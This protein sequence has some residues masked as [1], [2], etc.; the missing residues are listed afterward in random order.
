MT[1]RTVPPTGRGPATLGAAAPADL[2]EA[3]DRRRRRGQVLVIALVT[4]ALGSSR[5]VVNL[6]VGGR[7]AATATST[8][9]VVA[10]GAG[11]LAGNVAAA[12]F[13]L[14]CLGVVVANVAQVRRFPQLTALI[15]FL[16]FFAVV[17]VADFVANEASGLR[18]SYYAIAVLLVVGWSVQPRF[19]D[20]GIIGAVGLLVAVASLA[21]I[22][23]GTGWMS[24]SYATLNE[25]ALIGD[26]TLGGIYPQG[27]ILGMVLSSTM[28][29]ML[30]FKRR[31]LG[32]ASFAVG[33]WA[34]L[35][36][37]SRTSWAGLAVSTA[38]VLV[39]LA[40]R[41]GRV[42]RILT[43][44]GAVAITSVV[45]ALPILTTDPLAFT[46]RGQIW[47]YSREH[48]GSPTALLFGSGL[49]VYGI[50]GA[51]AT[52]LGAPSY[53][54]H[55]EFVTLMT[56]SG[57]VA[58]VLF[59]VLFGLAVAR[60]LM[61]PIGRPMRTVS[62]FL[63]TLIG[64][65]IAETPLRIDTVDLLAWCTWLPLVLCFFAVTGSEGPLV[66]GTADRNRARAV[67]PP[68]ALHRLDP[69]RTP[70]EPSGRRA[71]PWR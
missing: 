67:T 25:K 53:H 61:L 57:L 5:S 16:V 31:L 69:P 40:A 13:V 59:A 38:V 2:A 52:A 7:A 32:L 62:Y 41:K 30:L 47:I 22:P 56:T 55:N 49:D 3:R 9:T 17:T 46:A 4:F 10:T 66:A 48:W 63:L 71:A 23:S 26:R 45:V 20:L 34:L 51:I 39:L 21:L 28:P 44:L 8:G 15:L 6:L 12:A 54:G 33:L 70:S 65:S 1:A 58:A 35:L 43:V 37:A 42:L 24:E 68:L 11:E 18:F 14:A 50:G 60:V 29:L 36:T 19:E 27:N 64:I